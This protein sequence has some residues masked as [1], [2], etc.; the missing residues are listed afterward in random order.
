MARLFGGGLGEGG[1]GERVAVA[2][3]GRERFV[4]KPNLVEAVP[5][6]ITTP[7]EAVAAI[8]DELR[9]LAP[10]IQVVVAEGVGAADYETPHAFDELG[11]T[12][13][14]REKGV[15]LV[16]LNSAPLV[17]LS[18]PDCLRWP[19][20]HLPSLIMESFLI[21][22]PV[23]KAHSLSTVTLTMKNMMGAVPPTHYQAGGHWK[24]SAFHER[25]EESILDLCR[26]RAPDFTVLDATVG[27]SEAHLWGPQCDPPVGRV[28]ASFDPVAIDA[29]GAGLLGRRWQDVGHIRGADGELGDASSFVVVEVGS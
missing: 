10:H 19:V 9:R 18:N 27:M 25:I 6:P 14:A 8:I 2:A 12:A 13:M 7:V 16:D 29:Y 20:M 22:V 3:E 17:E 1:L 11:Y 15:E 4:I 24:K 21:S 5:P 23:L 26:Y 28:V